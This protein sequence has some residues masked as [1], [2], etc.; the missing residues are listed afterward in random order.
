MFFC[1]EPK[2]YAVL[3]KPHLVLEETTAG[4]RENKG[5]FLTKPALVSYLII[6]YNVFGICRIICFVLLFKLS[7][8][9]EGIVIFSKRSVIQKSLILVLCLPEIPIDFTKI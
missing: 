5:R 1:L 6:N 7:I 4:F 9:D 8:A 3:E 2:E